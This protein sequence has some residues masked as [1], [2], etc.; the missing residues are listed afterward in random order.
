M[1]PTYYLLMDQTYSHYLDRQTYAD[2]ETVYS[3]DTDP[4]DLLR[5]IH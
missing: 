2:Y 3:V 4:D 5:S 1:P